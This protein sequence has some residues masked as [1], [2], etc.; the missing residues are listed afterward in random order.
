MTIISWQKW[1]DLVIDFGLQTYVPWQL[2][3]GQIL[4]VDIVYFNGP[5]SVYLHTLIFKI[6]GPGI[7]VLSLFN[8]FLIV[9][10]AITIYF[11]FKKFSDS[12]TAFLSA[13]IF[14]LVFAFGQ[15]SKGGNFNFVNPY[16]YEIT[17]GVIL[18]FIA[19][20]E[21][22]N[23]LETRR[24]SKIITTGILIGLVFLTKPEASLAA[25]IAVSSGF[26][27]TVYLEKLSM[28]MLSKKIFLFMVSMAVPSLIFFI[29]FLV[30]MPPVTAFKAILGQWP[31]VFGSTEFRSMDYYKWIMGTDSISNN[32]AI[33]IVYSL[34]F[35][36]ALTVLVFINHK[37]I[38]FK[39]NSTLP[40]ILLSSLTLSLAIWF[41]PKIPWA[42]LLKPLPLI[43]FCF[44]I[45]LIIRIKNNQTN[46]NFLIQ[47]IPLATLTLFSLILLSKMILNVHVYHYG[48]ALA[49]PGALILV[50]IMFYE[51]PC[52]AKKISLTAN[53]YR[54]VALTVILVFIFSHTFIS[55]QVY[56]LNGYAVGEGRDVIQDYWLEL[57]PRGK[58]FNE[59]L[60]FINEE[61]PS[62]QTIATFPNTNMLNYLSRRRSPIA[63][64]GYTLNTWQFLGENYVLDLLKANPPEYI[65]FVD[66]NVMGFN[67]DGKGKGFGI[68][69]FGRGYGDEIYSWILGNYNIINQFG[70]VPFEGKGFGIQFLQLSFSEKFQKE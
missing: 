30:H 46:N 58:I 16:V 70:K 45:Y 62:D 11:L 63:T 36:F 2:S 38:R 52:F 1:A 32:V 10:L 19:I 56:Q 31:Y 42:E 12:K 54:S 53:T 33:I 25:I 59:A 5:F 8:L 3:Q 28:R 55:Y 40:N 37:L 20:Y 68:G 66:R 48:F 7:M 6:F 22:Q 18:S 57:S 69:G 43:L 34:I 47:K 44:G 24:N 65:A 27:I 64:L 49:M 21:L 50:V 51:I 29:F 14:I 41:Y 61:I 13:L 39:G 35:V 17:H 67:P 26:F 9:C 15:Y 23:Y 60:D 4:H